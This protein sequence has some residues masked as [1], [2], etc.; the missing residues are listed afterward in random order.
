[1][2][3]AGCAFAIG[4]HASTITPTAVPSTA[5]IARRIWSP[6]TEI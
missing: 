4:A 2:P 1:V 3:D 5:R 6:R